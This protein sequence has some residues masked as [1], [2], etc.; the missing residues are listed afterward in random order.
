M[1]TISRIPAQSAES[2]FLGQVDPAG[3]ASSHTG[4][5]IGFAN[6]ANYYAATVTAKQ[7]RVKGKLTSAST[8]ASVPRF[9]INGVEVLSG[10]GNPFYN[11][12]ALTE[13]IIYNPGVDTTFLLEIYWPG[14]GIPFFLGTPTGGG[15]SAFDGLGIIVEADGVPSLVCPAGLT[16]TAYK[17][18]W[19]NGAGDLKN[20]Q[21]ENRGARCKSQVFELVGT[22]FVLV[23]PASLTAYVLDG[24]TYAHTGLRTTDDIVYYTPAVANNNAALLNGS[25]ISTI[26]MQAVKMASGLTPVAQDLW[27]GEYGTGN[28]GTPFWAIVD[29][30]APALNNRATYPEYTIIGYDGGNTGGLASMPVFAT[31]QGALGVNWTNSNDGFIGTYNAAEVRNGTNV[32]GEHPT[33]GWSSFIPFTDACKT[34]KVKWLLH[35]FSYEDNFAI[36]GT[37]YVAIG[38]LGAGG[39]NL[40][41]L[42]SAAQLTTQVGLMA[43]AARAGTNW[44]G[45]AVA[46]STK[47]DQIIFMPYPNLSHNTYPA[48]HAIN[49]PNPPESVD[50]PLY[51]S[52]SPFAQPAWR[53][54]TGVNSAYWQC[55]IDAIDLI[56]VTHG[57]ENLAGDAPLAVY[58]PLDE[59][60]AYSSQYDITG[61][62]NGVTQIPG[63]PDGPWDKARPASV[64]APVNASD[65]FHLYPL[66]MSRRAPASVD[67]YL[68]ETGVIA[69]AA[70]E[71]LNIIVPAAGDRVRF[72]FDRDTVGYNG[73]SVLVNGVAPTGV[74]SRVSLREYL[75]TLT[76]DVIY[77]T[78]SVQGV[79]APGN[80]AEVQSSLPM[81]GFSMEA[82]NQSEEVSPTTDPTI[83]S[84]TINEANQTMRPGATFQF[85]AAVSALNNPDTTLIWKTIPPSAG[86][87]RQDGRYEALTNQ[88]NTSLVI[89]ATSVFDPTKYDEVSVTVS[90]FPSVTEPTKD[91]ASTW[92]YG[93]LM[94]IADAASVSS[95]FYLGGGTVTGLQWEAGVEGNRFYLETSPDNQNWTENT[96][97]ITHDANAGAASLT[98]PVGATYIRLRNK[99]NTANQNLTGAQVVKLLCN[100]P[101]YTENPD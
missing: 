70:P 52:T 11:N 99:Q 22:D 91:I 61:V 93:V 18:E 67:A 26:G 90:G 68:R 24:R 4:Y 55:V 77:S 63:L 35:L 85:T 7:L 44:F 58:I 10:T 53:Y 83:V 80:A 3:S 20:A 97:F 29:G 41:L 64:P 89:R 62:G 82:D 40:Q 48:F 95:S 92:Q 9:F 57:L 5:R 1:P 100:G 16:G 47:L 28:I 71:P 66:G 30:P 101:D 94:P 43:Q 15:T 87:V 33:L 98:T 31:E 79:Y 6:G 13:A 2:C 37:F 36:A 54:S 25:L 14:S 39:A 51:A 65:R 27:C 59:Y 23:Q 56:N 38:P 42:N 21:G 86:Y 72:I 81:V 84:V 49:Y 69:N 34:S 32:W 45:S 19:S 96:E 78:D 60:R 75:F 12:A 88:A 76:S 46:A 17:L 74:L 50:A 73:F 8:G